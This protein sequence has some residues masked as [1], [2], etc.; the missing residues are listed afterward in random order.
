MITVRVGGSDTTL[1][2]T[3]R[4]EMEGIMGRDVEL[5]ARDT[6]VQRA[7][8]ERGRWLRHPAPLVQRV[9]AT[10]DRVCQHLLGGRPRVEGDWANGPFALPASTP[11]TSFDTART[12][13]VSS[14]GSKGR[15]GAGPES[16]T[17]G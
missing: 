1:E 15:G 3:L 11:F 2:V 5:P 12:V 10:K 16:S 14:S 4:L 13:L 17:V 8:R 9:S 7:T 6:H